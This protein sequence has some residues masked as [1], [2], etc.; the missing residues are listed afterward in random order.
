ML[1]T[2]KKRIVE[3]DGHVNVKNS[4]ESSH[5]LTDPVGAVAKWS[6]LEHLVVLLICCLVPWLIFA[7]IWHF[8]FWLHGD[9]EPEHLPDKQEDSGWTP[10]V[11]AIH[12]FTSSLLF[13][14]ETQ[15]S[16]G[17][18]LRGTSHK[19]TDSV[20]LEMLQS[21]CAIL[22]ECV[23]GVIL[24]IKLTRGLSS[25]KTI[26]FSHNAVVSLRNGQLK[27]M[28]RAMNIKTLK[29]ETTYYGYIVHKVTTKEGEEMNHHFTRISLS[30]QVDEDKH[31]PCNLATPVL[32]DIVSHTMDSTSPCTTSA[33]TI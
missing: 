20:I 7:L 4:V 30:T 12:S 11:F 16:I 27:L 19:C 3:K 28:F 32:P 33:Q 6:F 15:R 5:L 17:Y 31:I 18:G 10:C 23:I 13:S 1:L 26:L 14:L 8:T 2:H 24:Y 29:L 9:L 22:I 21:I 25:S